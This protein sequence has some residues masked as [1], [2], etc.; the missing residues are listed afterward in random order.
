MVSIM[1]YNKKVDNEY[2]KFIENEKKAFI[3]G[4]RDSKPVLYGGNLW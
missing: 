1:E 4:K 3:D 2:K